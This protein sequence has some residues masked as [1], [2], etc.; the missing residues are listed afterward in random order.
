MPVK[1][2][3]IKK[4]KKLAVDDEGKLVM[5]F[6]IEKPKT[7]N[8]KRDFKL[9]LFIHT[10]PVKYKTKEDFLEDC[11]TDIE[12][13]EEYI[14]GY[15]SPKSDPETIWI[16]DTVKPNSTDN[17]ILLLH[18]LMEAVN[19]KFGMELEQGVICTIGECYA[20]ILVENKKLFIDLLKNIK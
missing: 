18:E 8:K 3:I 14:K 12:D 5:E 13:D 2:K 1:K 19:D 16:L 7:K 9:K 6:A 17:F 20:S 11:A 4:E 15:W 10:I